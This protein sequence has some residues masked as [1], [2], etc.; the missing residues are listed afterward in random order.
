MKVL[1]FQLVK[2]QIK[3]YPEWEE[4]SFVVREKITEESL[5]QE[6]M[7]GLQA[8]EDFLTKSQ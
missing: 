5:Q 6:V 8:W 2:K 4:D 7:T 1:K 3:R